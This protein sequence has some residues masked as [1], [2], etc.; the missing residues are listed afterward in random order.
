METTFPHTVLASAVASGV[1]ECPCSTDSGYDVGLNDDSS[2]IPPTTSLRSAGSTTC[3]A[4]RSPY[5]AIATDPE[6]ENMSIR[7]V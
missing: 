7:S 5:M 1:R 4:V 3:P 6:A 2:G